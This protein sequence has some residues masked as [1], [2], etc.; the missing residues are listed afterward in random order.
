MSHQIIQGDNVATLKTLEDNSIDSIITDPPYGIEFLGKDWDTNTGAVETWQEC[1]RVLKP[2]GYLLAF[3]AARTYHHLATNIESVGFEIRDQLMWLYASGFPKAQ[4]IGKAIQRRQ[5]VEETMSIEEYEKLTG[6]TN[7]PKGNDTFG[8]NNDTDGQKS[9]GLS[10]TITIPTSP[11]AQQWSGWKTALKPA[12]E[13][14]VMARKPFKGSTIDN[15]LKHGVGALNIDESRVSYEGEADFKEYVN[16]IK[17][18]L[19]RS[20]ATHGDNI[21]MHEGKTGFKAQK[22]R[23]V[24]PQGG[25]NGLSRLT[26]GEGETSNEDS[27]K[28]Y[29]PNEQGRFPSNVIGE[30]EGYQKYFYCPKV[31]RRER[32]CGFEQVPDP[33]ENY[34]QGDVKNHPLWDPS[35]GTNLQRLKH[36]IMEHN[37]DLGKKDPLA[38]IPAN[39]EGMWDDGVQFQER[40]QKQDPLAH[41]PTPFG[42][43]QGAYQDGERFAAKH[44]KLQLGDSA[45]QGQR[46]CSKD[47]YER[48]QQSIEYRKG[49]KPDPLAH[50]KTGGNFGDALKGDGEMWGKHQ[51]KNVGNNHPTVKPVALM[52]WLINLVTPKNSKVLD[53]FS[54]SGSTGM[55]AVELGH[56]FIGCELDPN[57]VEIAQKRIAG[58][59]KP[60]PKDSTFEDIFDASE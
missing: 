49:G 32:H 42:D 60:Q 10:G 30:V 48:W 28:Q 36:K 50:I 9:A 54:G 24:L 39:P 15:V 51:S 6:V 29:T 4:D 20:T 27:F 11:E 1:L 35:I 47:S 3:S 40:K 16:N 58:W 19:E 12:H 21:G 44:Q 52:R 2:G 59:N 25:A 45:P 37:R 41:I 5:G 31:S 7:L 22:G 18:P 8:H 55:A 46:R 43:V 23:V 13:P 26:F 14:I 33:L 34:S 17:G 53:P 38:H 57:Y 56:E